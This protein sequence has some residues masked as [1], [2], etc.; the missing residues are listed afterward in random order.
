MAV[1]SCGE[2]GARIASRPAPC[3]T[4]MPL[5][6][7]AAGAAYDYIWRNIARRRR[8]GQSDAWG[9]AFTASFFDDRH[10]ARPAGR[11][12]LDLHR[13]TDDREA[14]RGQSLQVVQLLEMAIADMAAGFVPFPD[15]RRVLRLG[16][17]LGRVDERRVPAPSVGAGQAHA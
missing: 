12:A 16:E 7:S 4:P 10:G 3:C 9:S 6:F 5:P 13:E 17:F 14:G 11:G 1:H 15:Q 2:K 8:E